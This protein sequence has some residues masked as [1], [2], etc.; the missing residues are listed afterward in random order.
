[1]TIPVWRSSYLASLI[2]SEIVG[3][4]PTA[5]TTFWEGSMIKI[6]EMELQEILTLDEL[7]KLY[8]VRALQLHDGNKSRAA[9]ALGITS[10]TLY[11]KLHEY[12]MMG[13]KNETNN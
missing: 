12:G 13:P 2:S 8:I 7:E 3:A 4:N 6:S 10:K 11:N 9:Q 1:M 5:G